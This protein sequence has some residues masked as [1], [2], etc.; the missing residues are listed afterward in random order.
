M[1]DIRFYD[2]YAIWIIIVLFILF[3]I[4][5][6]F[7]GFREKC[8]NVS[9]Y[10]LS[11]I[12]VRHSFSGHIH[13][14]VLGMHISMILVWIILASS[15][16]IIYNIPDIT[17]YRIF[18]YRIIH[19]APGSIFY[20]TRSDHINDLGKEVKANNNYLLPD[21]VT[22][23]EYIASSKTAAFL[24]IRN[25]TLLYEKYNRNYQENSIFNIFFITKA[26]MTTL[27]GI[28]IDEGLISSVD[29]AITDYIPELTKIE[30]FHEI[31]I[32]HLLL[33]TSGIKFSD[34]KFNPFSDNARYYYGR[35]LR[36]L[37]RKAKLYEKPGKEIRYS[38]A[39]VQLLGLM[40]ERATGT[41]IST[42]LQEKV[43]QK[44]GMQY[45]A[46]WNV[47]NRR[48][49]PVEKCFSNLNCT[50]IDLAKLGRLYLNNGY[51]DNQPI[52][53]EKFIYEATCRD[54]TDGSSLNFQYNFSPGPRPYDSFYASGLFGQLLLIHPGENIIIVRVGEP[55]LNY[56]PQFIRNNIFRIIDQIAE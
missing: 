52:L 12:K 15:C 46:R 1:P 27:V 40:L 18:P 56:N 42:Y 17:D 14:H 22:L 49:K 55:D 25:D 8:I 23:D 32:R 4:I 31:T 19:H 28:A 38:S 5:G 37:V 47:D 29:Q 35:N 2:K 24:I 39:N 33:H 50:A 21:F 30:G 9:R 16:R 41:D 26:F 53:S 11:R 44:I 45:D 43:W 6:I 13:F 10:A 34:T 51:W 54:T 36:K 3:V 7:I 48:K 20:F